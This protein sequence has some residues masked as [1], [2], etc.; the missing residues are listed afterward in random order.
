MPQTY[1]SQFNAILDT[2]APTLLSELELT[3][4]CVSNGTF[5]RFLQYPRKLIL[6]NDMI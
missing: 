3:S 6:L 2:Q 4:F 1:S 5:D